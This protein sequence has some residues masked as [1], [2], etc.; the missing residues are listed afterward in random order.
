MKP[1]SGHPS[2]HLSRRQY[3][4]VSIASLVAAAT[5][6][7]CASGPRPAL[8]SEPDT[9]MVD[10]ERFT[11]GAIP[12]ESGRDRAE[13]SATVLKELRIETLLEKASA[14]YRLTLYDESEGLC[15][16]VLQLD[17]GNAA[18]AQLVVKARKERLA[19]EKKMDE[20]EKAIRRDSSPDVQVAPIPEVT[21]PEAA[22]IAP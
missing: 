8:H 21:P 14:Y 3:L 16:I 7:G 22:P 4:P 13:R 18:A 19:R 20:A 5:L 6:A 15:L 2:R 12:P 10:G 17:P 9:R 11:M 1:S